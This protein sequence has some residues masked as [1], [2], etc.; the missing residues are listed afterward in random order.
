MFCLFEPQPPPT[1]QGSSLVQSF[2]LGLT[3]NFLTVEQINTVSQ[4]VIR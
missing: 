2:V 1:W 3:I 4:N